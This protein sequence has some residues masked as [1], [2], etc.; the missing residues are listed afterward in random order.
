MGK[1]ILCSGTYAKNPYYMEIGNINIYSIEELSYYIVNNLDLAIE[2]DFNKSLFEWIRDELKLES[3]ADGLLKLQGEKVSNKTL[4]Q[5][6]LNSSNYYSHAQKVKIN[7]KIEDLENLPILQRKIQKANQ[8]LA[9]RSFKEAEREYEGI[10]SG[11]MADELSSKEYSLILNNLGIAKLYTV[12]VKEASVLFKQAY[13]CN[14]ESES[15]RQ[16]C[17]SLKLSNQ[18]ELFN[19]EVAKYDLSEEWILELENELNNYIN[20]Y[21]SSNNYQEVL[22]LK[23]ASHNDYSSFSSEARKIVKDLENKYRRCINENS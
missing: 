20:D 3:L 12:G 5:T 2:L 9:A 11:D 19:E 7:H 21:E 17:L 22:R 6:I 8:F 13:E 1:L 16:Y 10:I 14:N 4:I 18:E 23:A 15:L